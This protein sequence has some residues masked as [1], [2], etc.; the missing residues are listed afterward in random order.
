MEAKEANVILNK[1]LKRV[2]LELEETKKQLNEAVM[3]L[4]KGTEIMKKVSK[5]WWFK[6]FAR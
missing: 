3:L 2:I 5:S 4:D 1:E 6:L